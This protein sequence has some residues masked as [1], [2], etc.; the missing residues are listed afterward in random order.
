MLIVGLR[1]DSD[2]IH[3]HQTKFPCVQVKYY[4]QGIQKRCGCIPNS[5]WLLIA[6]IRSIMAIVGGHILVFFRHRQLPVPQL[7]HKV[8][9]T[10]ASPQKV[11]ALIHFRK[12][13]CITESDR[14]AF[15]IV[16]AHAKRSVVLRHNND[17]RR[18]FQGCRLNF[19]G[20]V[21]VIGLFLH[22]FLSLRPDPIQTLP[23]RL[24]AMLEDD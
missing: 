2:I 1:D 16:D 5:K 10:V 22:N 17:G 19:V 8:E 7:T 6:S 24:R 20:F 4:V 3:I 14:V 12:S 9:K 13:V 18:S 21:H 11:D 15:P 23:D